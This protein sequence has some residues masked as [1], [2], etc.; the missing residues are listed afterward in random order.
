V[1]DARRN[2]IAASRTVEAVRFYPCFEY[3]DVRT[4]SGMRKI[5]GVKSAA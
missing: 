5:Y 1:S 2:Q 3:L 4:L